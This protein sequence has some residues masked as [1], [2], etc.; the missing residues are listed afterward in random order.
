MILQWQLF[1]HLNPGQFLLQMLSPLCTDTLAIRRGVM[2]HITFVRC[3]QRVSLWPAY[4]EFG[5]GLL[6]GCITQTWNCVC[7]ASSLWAN[8]AIKD[9]GSEMRSHCSLFVCEH[10][11]RIRLVSHQP[12]CGHPISKGENFTWQWMAYF[13]TSFTGLGSHKLRYH[14]KIKGCFYSLKPLCPADTALGVF[15]EKAACLCESVCVSECV[16]LISVMLLLT[17]WNLLF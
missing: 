5:A 6:W 4:E 16:C 12:L 9:A 7:M 13:H 3:H 14:Y 2:P 8:A 11:Q 1:I 10:D 17:V 15:V